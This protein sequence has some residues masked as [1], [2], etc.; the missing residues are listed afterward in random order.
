MKTYCLTV[1]CPTTRGIVAAIAT[2]LAERGCNIVDRS[3]SDDLVPGRF[4]MRVVEASVLARALHAHA[5]RRVFL[6]GKKTV[7]FSAQFRW[8]MT[9]PWC[10]KL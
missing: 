6:N 7:V 1:A 9:T 3:Q 5:H 2:F 4:F 8:P 10:L